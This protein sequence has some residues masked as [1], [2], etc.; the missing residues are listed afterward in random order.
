MQEI[1]TGL[2]II[3]NL[4]LWQEIID[5]NEE[6]IDKMDMEKLIPAI[7]K[8]RL[9]LLIRDITKKEKKYQKNYKKNM[10]NFCKKK[11]Y[12]KEI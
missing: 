8:G 9:I 6:D 3:D 11:D 12:Q 2:D 4:D 5:G 1:Y 10:Q 7:Q